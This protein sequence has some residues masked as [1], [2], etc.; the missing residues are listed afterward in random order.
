MDSTEVFLSVPGKHKLLVNKVYDELN[1][2]V[3]SI[4]HC[5]THSKSSL[6]S[7]CARSLSPSKLQF[8]FLLL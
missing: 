3:I 4:M 1:M 6:L 8:L 2:V 5:L 7:S